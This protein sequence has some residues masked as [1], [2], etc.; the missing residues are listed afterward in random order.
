MER[1]SCSAA[2]ANSELTRIAAESGTPVSEFA[3]EIAGLVPTGLIPADSAP[4]ATTAAGHA[5]GHEESASVA[6]AGAGADLAADGSALA[7][8]ML[9]QTLAEAG[10]VAVALFLIA[11]DGAIELAGEAG[12]G[13]GEA[14]RWRR[15]PPGITALA[16][17]AASTGAEFWW[18]AGRPDGDASPLLGHWDTGARVVLPLLT[19]AGRAIGSFEVCW[20]TAIGT[21]SPGLRRQLVALTELAVSALGA[22]GAG[23]AGD[24]AQDQVSWWLGLLD[25]LHESVLFAPAIRD[26]AGTAAD[27]RIVHVS[28]DFRDPAGRT[29]AELTG[30]SLIE[31]YPAAAMPGGLYQRAVDVLLTGTSQHVSGEVIGAGPGSS[32]VAIASVRI[33]RLFDGVVIV[34]RHAADT[35][36]L[37]ALLEHAQRLGRFGGWEENLTTG[38]VHWTQAMSAL[39]G[40]P[41]PD[42][43]RLA[44]LHTLVHVDDRPAIESFKSRLMTDK[45]PTASVFRI[46]RRDDG[47]VRQVR[48]FAEPVTDAYGE[49]VAVRGAYQDVS[50]HYHTELALAAT[51]DLLSDTQERADEEHRLAVRLQRAI[52][53]RSSHLVEAAGLD[54][55]ARYRPASQG[56]LVSGDWYDTVLL[57]TGQVMLVVGDVAGHGIDAVTGMVALRNCLRGLAI[58]GAGP[59]TLLSWLN[60]AAYHLTDDILGTA[61]CG[62]YDPQTTTLR[63]ARAGHLPAVLVRDGLAELLPQ[64]RGVLLGADPTSCYGEATTPLRLGD[65]LLMFTDGMIERRDQSIDD[66]IAAMLAI[67]SSPVTDIDAYADLLVANAVSDTEDDACLVAVTLR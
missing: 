31:A 54:V 8:A 66:S 65:T 21:F 20:P 32:Q 22:G 4:A 36:R 38:T 27:F 49:L 13:P 53:P 19:P 28:P 48:A 34:L 25:S 10:A 37:A 29:A 44:E 16:E 57:P 41:P 46:V 58:T 50:A 35:D 51:R 56:H 52:T 9:T 7:D 43:V 14:S 60:Q 55:A 40:V 45:V 3:A 64:P 24:Q 42:P 26:P 17:R 39:F 63:W 23:P 59:A 15:L 1:L 18:P 47:S 11:P 30:Q 62:L 6:L 61:S 2:A 67:A 33:A 12:F 5:N